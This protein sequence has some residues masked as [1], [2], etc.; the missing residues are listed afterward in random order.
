MHFTLQNRNPPLSDTE[1][2]YSACMMKRL[3]KENHASVRLKC[4]QRVYRS[5]QCP[6]LRNLLQ[7]SDAITKITFPTRPHRARGHL[8]ALVRSLHSV[9]FLAKCESFHSENT[10][11][12]ARCVHCFKYQMNHCP[13]RARKMSKETETWSLTPKP[14][15]PESLRVRGLV[16]HE[17]LHHHKDNAP[18]S[19]PLWSWG[20]DTP[21]AR[22]NCPG[23]RYA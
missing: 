17:E 20:S 22:R 3:C 21:E 14:R 10:S 7:R 6:A 13:A 9:H 15:V 12:K 8:R 23:H 19:V 5:M 11:L 18:Q 4:A 2:Q 16:M 1:R